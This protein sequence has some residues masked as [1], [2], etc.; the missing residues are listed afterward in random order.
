M[1]S[2]KNAQYKNSVA[3]GYIYCHILLMA[4]RLLDVKAA[5]RHTLECV[6]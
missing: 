4:Q 5:D 3:E 6:S 1:A 2:T